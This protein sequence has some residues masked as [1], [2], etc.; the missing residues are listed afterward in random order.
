MIDGTKR[1]EIENVEVLDASGLLM[2]CRVGDKTVGVPPLRLLPGSQ[3]RWTGDRG[4]VVLPLLGHHLL[5]LGRHE[6]CLAAERPAGD[7]PW[8]RVAPPPEQPRE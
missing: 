1:I 8:Q 5:I 7:W 6:R 4:R 3:V 2:R